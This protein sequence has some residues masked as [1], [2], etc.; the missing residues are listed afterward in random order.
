M[1][2]RD[3]WVKAS[4]RLQPC[5]GHWISRLLLRLE[6]HPFILSMFGCRLRYSCFDGLWKHRRYQRNRVTTG[7]YGLMG[8]ANKYVVKLWEVLW[9][10]TLVTWEHFGARRLFHDYKAS[11]PSCRRGVSQAGSGRT[12][13]PSAL[14]SICRNLV[15]EESTLIFSFSCLLSFFGC[16]RS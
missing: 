14:T 16:S 8:T 4:G 15:G 7:A 5:S 1:W 13:L 6:S 9:W 3:N 2:I 10:K 12:G 11:P